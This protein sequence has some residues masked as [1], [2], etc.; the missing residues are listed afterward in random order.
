MNKPGP[1][2][3]PRVGQ[4]VSEFAINGQEPTE[5]KVLVDD[6]VF[7]KMS[8][9]AFYGLFG[10]IAKHIEPVTE[11]DPVAILAQLLVG[12]GNVIGRLPFY[13]VEAEEHHSNLF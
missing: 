12:F 2:P 1:G 9:N 7:P 11:A 3:I 5:K 10:D 8:T 6:R 13:S 4:A